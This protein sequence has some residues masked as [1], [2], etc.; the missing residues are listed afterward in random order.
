MNHEEKKRND[1]MKKI[2]LR[3]ERKTINIRKG[4]K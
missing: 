4:K 2:R 3:L 1:K